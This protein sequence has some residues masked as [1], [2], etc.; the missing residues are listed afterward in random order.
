VSI[1]SLLED[2][3]AGQDWI[4]T[5]DV[6]LSSDG[7]RQQWSASIVE[8]AFGSVGPTEQIR[9]RHPDIKEFIM[10]GQLMMPGFVD[11]H[12]HLTQV[13]AKVLI[14]GQPAQIWKRMWMPLYEAMDPADAYLAAK[15]TALEALRGGFT[16]IV[17]A[18]ERDPAKVDP[19]EEAVAEVGIRCVMAHDFSDLGGRSP[20]LE[21][22][23]RDAV[24][25]CVRQAR[26]YLAR[27]SENSRLVRAVACASHQSASRGLIAEMSRLSADASVAF[28]IHVNEHTPE[29][30]WCLDTYGCRPI[31]MLHG[32]GALGPQTLLAHATLVSST[33]V[34]MLQE[35]G[36]GV[37]YN[38]VASAWKGNA[39]APALEFANRGIAFGLGTDATRSD[40]FRLMDAAETAQ[41]LTFGM[42]TIDWRCGDGRLWLRAA[43]SNGAKA[44]GLGGVTGSIAEGLR[45]DFLVLDCEQPEVLPSWDVEWELVRHYDRTN[46]AA[47]FV[48]GEATLIGGRPVGWD[49]ES[50]MDEAVDAGQRCV[51]NAD[52]RLIGRDRRRIGAG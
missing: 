42:R 51:Q 10:P 17:T 7:P 33:E 9:D 15:W 14:G 41:R 31:E 22:A 13:F 47:V 5:P 37:S 28:Q 32:I 27:P 3:N 1:T 44:A 26:E 19:I 4:A 35:S 50:F 30:E 8:G 23:D 45:A 11:T 43:T 48:D 2:F 16:T 38:P 49:L 52:M 39:V 24:Q 46:L 34:G 20:S 36:A 12:Q 29:V 40:G 18:G 6:L 21:P 25:E